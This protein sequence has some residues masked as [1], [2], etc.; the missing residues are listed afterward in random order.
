VIEIA[1]HGVR[2][3]TPCCGETVRRY[4]G[5]T[6][7]VSAHK[8]DEPPVVF[9]LGTGL[10]QFGLS[11]P[12]DEPYQGAVLLSHLH[13]DHVQGLPFF[14]PLL[15]D[16][17]EV[18]IWA[19]VQDD[20]RSVREAFDIFMRPPYFPVGIDELPGKIR[21]HDV[22]DETFELGDARVMARNIPHVGITNG[23][24][25]EWDDVSVAYLPDHQQPMNGFRVHDN[26]LA[27][28]EGADLVIH[29]AQYTPEEF[30]R[31]SSWGHCTIE[32]AMRVAHE[33]G[34]KGLALFHHDPLRTDDDLDETAVCARHIADK[35]G[36]E[37]F[38][39]AE[40]MRIELGR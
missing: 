28:C 2:G 8:G 5:N 13:W 4:G 40:G 9:D 6:A 18:D 38:V 27:L 3:S 24:R 25:L 26:A 1:F 29:D 39:A 23:Y 37:L 35:L 11:R 15:R 34:A 17:A 32:F 33:A 31:K 19:P 12:V 36:I 16:G 10:R 30:K 20:G 14:V 22:G 21:F 7:C